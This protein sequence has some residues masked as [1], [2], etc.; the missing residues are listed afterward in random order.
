M[1]PQQ[2]PSILGFLTSDSLV[3]ASQNQCN[4]GES[5][6]EN[7]QRPRP[8]SCLWWLWPKKQQ[9]P[10]LSFI[11]KC[12]LTLPWQGFA[13]VAPLVSEFWPSFFHNYTQDSN[14]RA[15]AFV[16]VLARGRGQGELASLVSVVGGE[17]VVLTMEEVSPLVWVFGIT[18]TSF[19]PFFFFFWDKS[20][21]NAAVWELEVYTQG[22][23]F[24]SGYQ[25]INVLNFSF[26]CCTPG[27]M[28]S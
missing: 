26:F 10:Q 24:F 19:L 18:M 7:Q 4:P 25:K 13:R 5:G 20:N 11:K 14:S 15:G 21:S 22:K 8:L 6:S 23:L 27:H 28:G 9:S 3:I 17:L 1:D 16:W 12:L 2:S